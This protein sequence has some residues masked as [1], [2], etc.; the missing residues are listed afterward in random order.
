[1]T[2][3]NSKAEVASTETSSVQAQGASANS[4]DKPKAS[5]NRR[6]AGRRGQGWNIAQFQVEP[7]EGKARF[8]DFDL[9]D[10]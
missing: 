8:H 5:R 4:A 1:L 10:N 7:V 6:G 2:E 3:T 9:P